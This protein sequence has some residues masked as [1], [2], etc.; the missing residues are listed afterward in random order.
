MSAPISIVAAA[1]SETVKALVLGCGSE[2]GLVSDAGTGA[3]SHD[4]KIALVSVAILA[5]A[6]F[7]IWKIL[8]RLAVDAPDPIKY[9]H[10]HDCACPAC[11]KEG[12]ALPKD[13]WSIREGVVH[14][15]EPVTFGWVPLM[16]EG[17]ELYCYLQDPGKNG[18]KLI[19]YRPKYRHDKATVEQW[20]AYEKEARDTFVGI[21]D[22]AIYVDDVLDRGE[23]PFWWL[24][25]KWNDGAPV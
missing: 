13:K 21:Q 23:L 3:T 19:A 5:L 18:A 7:A 12:V 4:W 14:E 17:V 6:A 2:S 15:T 16:W 9:D 22:H 11:H 20:S 10:G 8:P 1:V 24:N 25:D